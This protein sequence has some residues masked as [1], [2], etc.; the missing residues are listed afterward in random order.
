[1]WT[2]ATRLPHLL[3][4]A[5][6]HSREQHERE[7]ARLLLP[8]WHPVATLADLPRHGDFITC[9]LLGKPL[10]VRNERG[11]IRAFLNVCAHRHALLTHAPRGST[12]RLRC[13]YHGWEYDGDGAACK[14]PDAACFVPVRRGSE[15]LRAYRV[16]TLGQLVFVTLD[17]QAPDLR[18]YLGEHVWGLGERW[19]AP[20]LRQAVAV[21]IDH[22]CNWKIPLENVLESYHV[23]SLHD[24]FVARHPGLF[25]LFRGERAG[26]GEV[27]ELTDRF[28]T[29]RDSL[30]ADS[31]LYRGVVQ[32]LRPGASLDFVHLHAFP[33]LLFGQTSLVSFLQ[34]VTPT[35]PT[36]SRSLVRMFLDLGQPDRGLVERALAPLAD[37]LTGELFARLM[38][39][40][41]PVFP[42]LQR[43]LGASEQP[44][45]LGSR[46]ER[47][48]AFHTF[49]ARGT[50]PTHPPPWPP[51]GANGETPPILPL[52]PQG[53]GS[54][55][56]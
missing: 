50:D 10:I 24:N 18:S 44:G 43:G 49:V 40:D 42:D 38:R 46:E 11:Q 26:G 13:Q 37:R 48:H 36:T 30:G 19:F 6:Y 27:H 3:P 53:E 34:V 56:G 15:R 29:V 51:Q 4:P 14:I 52:T 23:P 33:N 35:S 28:S 2:H 45:V 16:A 9:E 17:D 1:M 55:D 22:P 31:A 25:R 41:A 7:M 32:R 12:P 5:A 47:I 20:H 54:E 39:E 8:G 21:S